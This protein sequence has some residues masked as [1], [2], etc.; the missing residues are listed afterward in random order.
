[1]MMQHSK[2]LIYLV[3]VLLIVIILF[4]FPAQ[5]QSFSVSPAEVEIANL[6]PGE[7]AQ[8]NLTIRNKEDVNHVFALT[9]YNPEES[10]RRE[11]RARFPDASWISFSPQSVEVE[12]N[13]EAKAKVTIVIPP[14]QKWA[15]KNWEIWLKVAPEEREFLVVNY[16]I[17]L[18]VSTGEEVEV[19][20]NVG[21][22]VGI[23]VGILLLGCV[24]Y[25]LR[26][27]AKPRHLIF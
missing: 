15:G 10:E 19:G 7:E 25:Y 3:G 24:V 13:S 12:A 6:S 14:N 11:G 18:L 26:R 1:M 9:T 4:P 8:F 27:K 5:A 20:T 22:V 17:R 2:Y 16:Y 23:V 21:L